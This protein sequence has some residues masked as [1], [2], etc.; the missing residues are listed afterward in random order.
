M[1]R[2]AFRHRQSTVA[3]FAAPLWA[4]L[5]AT[6]VATIMALAPAAAT[7]VRDKPPVPVGIDTSAIQIALLGDGLDYTDP[8]LAQ[9]LARDGEG[10]LI[11]LDAIDQ[12]LAPY[13]SQAIAAATDAA[14]GDPVVPEAQV[15]EPQ[16][17]AMTELARQLVRT[18]PDTAIA[19][20]R[21]AP[22]VQENLM[23][24]LSHLKLSPVR[25]VLLMPGFADDLAA[26]AVL[27]EA[28]SLL[29]DKV[30]VAPVNAA[31][32]QTPTV[33]ERL[34]VSQ[35]PTNLIWLTGSDGAVEAVRADAA[36]LRGQSQGVPRVRV[37]QGSHGYV[38]TLLLALT[39][40]AQADPAADAPSVVRRAMERLAS[41]PE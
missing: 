25:V 38:A 18:L 39:A 24:A 35:R 13:P 36:Q 19:P 4:G 34:L 2:S 14:L 10:L 1:M 28:A 33:R 30:L 9:R 22:G 41:W 8:V 26:Q 40:E 20:F 29:Q 31:P 17:A 3:G 27:R 11:G 12:D 7:T 23:A 32:Q 15:A 16:P 6:L 5:T 37:P 21:I